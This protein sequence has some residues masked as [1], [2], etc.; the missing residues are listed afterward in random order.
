MQIKSQ[1]SRKNIVAQY[2]EMS[3]TPTTKKED[4]VI[5]VY[6]IDLSV[7]VQELEETQV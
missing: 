7:S 1:T 6:Q 2:R 4:F 5:D 3:K